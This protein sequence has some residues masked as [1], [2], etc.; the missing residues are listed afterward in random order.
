MS[1]TLPFLALVRCRPTQ[2]YALLRCFTVAVVF[3][4]HLQGRSLTRPRLST[5]SLLRGLLGLVG[6]W[7]GV[8][9]HIGVYPLLD[10]LRFVWIVRLSRQFRIVGCSSLTPTLS[11]S[12]LTRSSYTSRKSRPA[13]LQGIS[14]SVFGKNVVLCPMSFNPPAYGGKLHTL[15]SLS[16]TNYPTAGNS[17]NGAVDAFAPRSSTLYHELFHLT[18]GDDQA[19]D[20][21][22]K[23]PAPR[24]YFLLSSPFPFVLLLS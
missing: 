12:F 2:L 10:R 7:V 5:V 19:P 17:A 22:S 24:T 3:F 16:N 20:F 23:W 1:H 21:T 15:A 8:Q 9:I 11:L 13:Q 6:E 18:V 4:S 14:S